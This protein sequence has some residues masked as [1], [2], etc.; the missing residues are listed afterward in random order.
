MD[1]GFIVRQ[2]FGVIAFVLL[3]FQMYGSYF[4]FENK[5][6]AP[7]QKIIQLALIWFVPVVGCLWVLYRSLPEAIEI[8]VGISEEQ[9][10]SSQVDLQTVK[11]TRLQERDNL[12]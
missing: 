5:Q 9:S 2:I 12:I 4:L 11:S 6:I 7:K 3:F 10:A 8:S 1:S